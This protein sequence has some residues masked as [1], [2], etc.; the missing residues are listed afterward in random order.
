MFRVNARKD[1]EGIWREYL[2]G[3]SVPFHHYPGFNQK[4]GNI[5]DTLIWDSKTNRLFTTNSREKVHALCT[6]K[7]KKVSLACYYGLLKTKNWFSVRKKSTFY[8]NCVFI[9]KSHN[10]YINILEKIHHGIVGKW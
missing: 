3:K 7:G 9:T 5:G 10:T 6:T 4:S 8:R 2:S 1:D